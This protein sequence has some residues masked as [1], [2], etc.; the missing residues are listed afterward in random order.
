M[1]S[2]IVG[3]IEIEFDDVYNFY[4]HAM[5]NTKIIDSDN[6]LVVHAKGFRGI[7]AKLK[8]ITSEE[9]ISVYKMCCHFAE[10]EYFEKH[11]GMDK[12]PQEYRFMEM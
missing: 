4:V 9:M 3:Q 6:V 7:R 11:I 10:R 8:D 2:V 1:D 12:L 5:S